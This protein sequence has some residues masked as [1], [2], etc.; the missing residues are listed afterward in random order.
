LI[1]VIQIMYSIMF[2]LLIFMFFIVFFDG[3]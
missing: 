1:N 2:M 3:G